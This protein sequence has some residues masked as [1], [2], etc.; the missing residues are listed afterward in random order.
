MFDKMIRNFRHKGLQKLFVSGSR[1]GIPPDMAVRLTLQLDALH[2]AANVQD[3]NLPGY[4]LHELQGAREGTW[5]ITVRANW[6]ITFRFMDGDALDV[7][8]EDYH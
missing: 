5:A 4:H 2:A 8:F 6:R 3:L 1:K 7:D